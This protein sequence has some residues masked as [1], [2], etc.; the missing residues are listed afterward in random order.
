[1]RILLVD[2]PFHSFM[3]YDQW[4]YP[5]SL[6][7]LAAV[8]HDSGHE[9]FIYD[10]DKYFYKDLETRKRSIFLKKQQLYYENVDNLE[11]EIWKHFR[12]TLSDL[13]PDLSVEY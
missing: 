2:P 9:A 3:H 1:M 6:A 5:C 8:A 4:F 7:Q 12:N 11:H 10:G 13:N